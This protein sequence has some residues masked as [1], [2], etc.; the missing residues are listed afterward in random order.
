MIFAINLT[1]PQWRSCFKF[2]LIVGHLRFS[3]LSWDIE[4]SDYDYVVVIYTPDMNA[5]ATGLKY[6]N[7][8]WIEWR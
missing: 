3:T 7:S 8:E 2:Q 4:V 5:I 1:L 6:A